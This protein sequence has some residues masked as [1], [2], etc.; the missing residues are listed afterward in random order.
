MVFDVLQ[1][2]MFFLSVYKY[3]IFNKKIL[4][5]AGSIS[6]AQME[7]QVTEIYNSFDRRRKEFEA[8]QADNQDLE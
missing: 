7:T 2:F 1:V 3:R 8:L 6:K 5:N 4:S